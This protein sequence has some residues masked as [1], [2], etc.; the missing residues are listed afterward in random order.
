MAREE[1]EREDLLRDAVALV[2]RAQWCTVDGREVFL[3]FRKNGG[4]SVYFDQDP[5]YH[6]TS[7]RQLRR[8]FV[9]NQLIKAEEHRLV[10]M[11]RE[12]PG[13]EVQLV[14]RML[15][16]AA[17]EQF[18]RDLRTALIALRDDLQSNR[19]HLVGQVPQQADLE[20]R[21]VAWL[22]QL[23]D[24]PCQIASSPHAT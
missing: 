19:L 5:V 23:V 14:S 12:R 1:H 3:G 17:T 15:D 9:D 20:A 11:H 24:E 2:E 22:N 4:L 8:A 21:S 16:E 6:F 7:D 10:E 13:G 18:L